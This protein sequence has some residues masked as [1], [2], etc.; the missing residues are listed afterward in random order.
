MGKGMVCG[1]V[2][3][4][5]VKQKL[6][7]LRFSSFGFRFQVSV[8]D[9]GSQVFTGFQFP[10]SSFL[11]NSPSSLAVFGGAQKGGGYSQR[12]GNQLAE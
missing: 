3:L 10:V 6:S 11:A 5:Q 2:R 1:E 9:A 12:Q 4:V 8:S 7:S